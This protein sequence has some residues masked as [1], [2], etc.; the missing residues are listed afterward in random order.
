MSSLQSYSAVSKMVVYIMCLAVPIIIVVTV[1]RDRKDFH[2]IEYFAT[3]VAAESNKIETDDLKTLEN[4]KVVPLAAYFDGRQQHSHRNATVILVDVLEKWVSNITGCDVDGVRQSK[5][6]VHPIFVTGWIKEKHPV[7]HTELIVQ[8]FDMTTTQESN[9]SVLFRVGS[10]GVIK[11]PVKRRGVVMPSKKGKE[12]DGVMVCASG[13]G[14]PALLQPWLIYQQT[15]G[16]KLVHLNVDVSFV[17]SYNNSK[18]LQN[19]IESGYVKMVSWT[20]YLNKS[21]V[22]LYS[23]SFKYQDCILRYQNVFKYM[24]IVD[25][26]EFFIPMG[27]EKTIQSYTKKLF[28][29]RSV[30]SV[31]LPSKRYYC[32]KKDLVNNW[33]PSDGNMT[34]LYDTSYSTR[35]STGKSIHIVKFVEEVSV[36]TAANL[37]PRHRKIKY[38]LG[39]SKC[40]IFHITEY[41]FYTKKCKH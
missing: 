28:S 15:I 10:G 8:C 35:S 4:I 14:K 25:F 7:S 34:K 37:F 32:K 26:D 16:I 1:L 29:K 27:R 24:M 30:A 20:P 23:Q 22:F 33:R 11:V 41:T 2:S 18:A 12:K 9:V 38:S 5:I 21:Q 19:L 31:T 39:Q 40:Y 13:Y 17:Q 3:P 36:H 6:R